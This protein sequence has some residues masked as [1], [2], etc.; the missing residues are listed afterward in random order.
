MRQMTTRLG[1]KIIAAMMAA[2]TA[3]IL[4]VPGFAQAPPPPYPQTPPPGYPQTPPPGYPQSYPQTP[5]PGYPQTAPPGYP[6]TPPPGY[7]PA[8]NYP[9]NYPPPTFTPQQLDQIVA[10]IALYP[11]PL[12]SQVLAAA[13]FS[14]QIP[15]AAR[16]A[17]QHHYLTG[18]A[19]A[20]AIQADRLP[21]DPSV[22]A[23]LPFP[24]VLDMMAA[25]MAWTQQ[26]GDAFLGDQGAVMDAVQRQR[27]L[28]YR[29]GYLRTDPQI[30]VTPGPYI[31]IAPVNPAFIYVPVY[32][33]AVVF[34]PPRPGFVVG[35][36]ITFGWGFSITAA[37]RPW[38]WAPGFAR[39]DWGAHR[40]FVNN[41]VWNR[42]FV[43]R[44]A[45]VHPYT[46]PRYAPARQVEGH[47]LHEPS[48]KEREAYRTGHERVEEH[49]DD[50]R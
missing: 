26:L 31:A 41:V 8:S 6:Q 46:V 2:L 20:A 36:A 35:G 14:Y 28:A 44:N 43:N 16:W 42:T 18:D 3:G 19:L 27:Q 32:N 11:D 29:Y 12:L 4:P 5:P 30:V 15:D 38:G 45:Y 49:H 17:D 25:N 13:T 50:R 47:A 37:F 23:L 7:P 33:P 40:V 39:F 1:T 24:N 10:G 22:Q 21:W 34:F 48:P 9:P